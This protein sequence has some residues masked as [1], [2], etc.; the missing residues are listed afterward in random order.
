MSLDRVTVRVPATTANIGPGFD[1]LGIALDMFNTVHVALSA[2][3][4]IE[5]EG[6]GAP[7]LPT[8]DKNLVYRAFQE[9]YRRAGQEAPHV[10]IRSVNAIPLTRGLGSSASA[11][12]GGA[13]AA[14]AFL[15]GA[16]P[17]AELLKV[18]VDIEGHPDNVTPALLGGFQVVVQTEEG[19]MV[20]SRIPLAEGLRVV[21]FIPEAHLSTKAARAVL[22]RRVSRK[23][24]VFNLGRATLLVNALSQ[25]EWKNLALAT[26]DRMHQPYR[27]A[28]LPILEPMIEAANGA[29][30]HG[31]F[32]SGAGPTIAAFATDNVDAVSAAM[33]RTA[34][35]WDAPGVI[36]VLSPCAE[37]AQIIEG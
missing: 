15:G 33:L 32:L 28:L 24:A 34:K 9:T 29:G 17:Q 1:C 26:Q 23:D 30:A 5:V 21:V 27:K 4:R 11:I 8:G 31:A 3:T 20:A 13:V 35:Q 2:E 6:E 14:N 12:V 25:G 37:G 22:P 19:G 10:A 36:K 7:F 18:V 16:V